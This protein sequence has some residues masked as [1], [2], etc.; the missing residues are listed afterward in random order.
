[1]DEGD[2]PIGKRV[3]TEKAFSYQ[4]PTSS[5]LGFTLGPHFAQSPSTIIRRD[6]DGDYPVV[7]KT[8]LEDS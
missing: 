4:D 2:S 3:N 6:G 5:N 7:W 1:M 8:L